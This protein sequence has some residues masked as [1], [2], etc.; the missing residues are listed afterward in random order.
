M[1]TIEKS[2]NNIFEKATHKPLEPPDKY[3]SIYIYNDDN[4]EDQNIHNCTTY[5]SI[6]RWKNNIRLSSALEGLSKFHKAHRSLSEI[7]YK[8]SVSQE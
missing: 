2:V 8:I 6:V 4:N 5:Q 1:K 7:S 3:E